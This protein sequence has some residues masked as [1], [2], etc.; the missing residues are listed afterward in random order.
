MADALHLQQRLCLRILCLRQK[1]NL[2]VVLL[3]LQSHLCNL[4]EYCRGPVAAQAA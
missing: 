3:D 4:L 2:S 1:L